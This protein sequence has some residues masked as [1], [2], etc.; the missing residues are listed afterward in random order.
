MGAISLAGPRSLES[1]TRGVIDS[2]DDLMGLMCGVPGIIECV[3]QTSRVSMGIR[4]LKRSCELIG[5]QRGGT[6]EPIDG[7]AL[8]DYY[9]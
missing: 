5:S 2:L 8:W 6:N 4:T 3:K 1:A 7:L 9:I